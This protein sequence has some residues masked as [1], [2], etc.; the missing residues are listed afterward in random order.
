MCSSWCSPRQLFVFSCFF[1]PLSVPFLLP[2]SV[3]RGGTCRGT[4]LN[5]HSEGDFGNA[6]DVGVTLLIWQHRCVPMFSPAGK[7]L[8]RKTGQV[9]D[10]D[11]PSILSGQN[12]IPKVEPWGHRFSFLFNLG[13]TAANFGS[14]CKNLTLLLFFIVFWCPDFTPISIIHP[15][16]PGI[17]FINVFINVLINANH[18]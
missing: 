16:M 3:H 15:L 2:W 6:K 14:W 7:Q 12:E 10:W 1:F 13:Q 11:V 17:W 5:F 9:W 8:R 4:S 18:L